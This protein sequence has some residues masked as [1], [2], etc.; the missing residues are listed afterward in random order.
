MGCGWAELYVTWPA[1]EGTDAEG[2]IEGVIE[3]PTRPDYYSEYGLAAMAKGRCSWAPRVQVAD[4]VSDGSD[5]GDLDDDHDDHGEGGA[6]GGGS[7]DDDADSG[8]DA[9]DGDSTSASEDG[10]GGHDG[11]ELDEEEAQLRRGLLAPPSTSV[12]TVRMSRQSDL[13]M[14]LWSADR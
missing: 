3:L 10:G 14:I 4:D 2:G 11:D 13:N 12:P 9:A 5:G 6:L 8:P 7:D 1:E